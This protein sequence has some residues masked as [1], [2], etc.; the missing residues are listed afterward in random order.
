V[1]LNSDST[2]DAAFFA[3]CC[4]LPV[5]AEKTSAKRS[6]GASEVNVL[7]VADLLAGPT[8]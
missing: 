7:A 1:A 3:G 5:G 2:A 6:L 4:L 8:T